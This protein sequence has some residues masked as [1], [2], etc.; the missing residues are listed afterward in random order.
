A[1]QVADASLKT[2]ETVDKTLK[3]GATTEVATKVTAPA[4]EGVDI[5]AKA[6]PPASAPPPPVE[7]LAS[8][9]SE[10]ASGVTGHQ[11]LGLSNQGLKVAGDSV[12]LVVAVKQHEVEEDAALQEK[13]ANIGNG[14]GGTYSTY[15]V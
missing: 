11:I 7:A 10:A 12:G 6:A 4:K 2:A 3:V 8:A 5:L 15:V 13:L 1:G 9:P 14:S